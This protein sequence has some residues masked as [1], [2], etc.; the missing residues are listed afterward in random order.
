MCADVRE[1]RLRE[2]VVGTASVERVLRVHDNPQPEP[3][4]ARFVTRR[5]PVAADD[6]ACAVAVEHGRDAARAQRDDHARFA[7]VRA[8]QRGKR[9][10]LHGEPRQRW[11][12]ARETRPASPDCSLPRDRNRARNATSPAPCRRARTLR[13]SRPRW[14]A[15]PARCQVPAPTARLPP[16]R[17]RGPARRRARRGC[18]CRRRQ[19]RSERSRCSSN[20]VSSVSE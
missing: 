19:C 17:V 7:A 12:P 6:A 10:L 16:A 18:R 11:A 5:K 20:R 13:R 8:Q 9:V 2:L 1:Q 4:T 3:R 14:I 15:T